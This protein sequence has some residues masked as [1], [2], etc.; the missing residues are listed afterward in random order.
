MVSF[1]LLRK[2][3]LQWN[4]FCFFTCFIIYF[5]SQISAQVWV[6]TPKQSRKVDSIFFDFGATLYDNDNYIYLAPSWNY[7]LNED[8]GF[9]FSLPANF[10]VLDREPT[11]DGQ[12]VGSLR[13]FDYNER[14]DYFR[15]VNYIWYGQYEREV[16]GK[17][18]FSFYAGDI[19]DGRIGNGT[20]LNQYYNNI[21]HDVYNV[22]ILSD[23]NSDYVGVQFFS[24]SL[25]S[26][27]V[28]AIR[29]YIKPLA[30]GR[31]LYHLYLIHKGMF[32][33]D[34]DEFEYVGMMQSRGNVADEA[35]RKK[36][37]EE[38]EEKKKKRKPRPSPQ[39]KYSKIE[40]EEKDEWYNR[41][42][43]G[44]TRA[45]DR[46]SPFLIGFS[47]N[48]FPLPR[49]N[50]DQPVV[51]EERRVTVEGFDVSYR[52]LNMKNIEFT[53]YLDVNRIRELENSGGTH[54]GFVVRIGDKD[55]NVVLRPELR[56]MSRNYIPMYFDT[57]YEVER[58][59]GIP[60]LNTPMNP[61]RNQIQALETTGGFNG[62]FHT[63]IFNFYNYAFEISYEDWE[64]PNNS[65]IFLASYIPLGSSFLLSF[66]YTKKGFEGTGDA[67]NVNNTAMG[68]AELS[69][70]LGPFQLRLQNIRKWTFV[71]TERNFK[72]FDEVRV[73]F[74]SQFIF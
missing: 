54:Y 28:N 65:R 23:F 51:N 5:S 17:T 40:I 20:I 44:Y 11:Q 56:R 67:L 37:L 42:T 46:N 74:S 12:N 60:D 30:I 4:L 52:F 45:F 32:Q 16:P 3:S 21:R 43:V 59:G 22:G 38:V 39:I 10:L 9:S 36:V 70:P 58:F 50:V 49:E 34:E 55:V 73:L 6:P 2:L 18:S 57:F 14:Q 53:T 68:A 48:G 72:A 66:Y 29:G 64:G 24:N 35:G 1:K 61:K 8:F 19:R 33:E 7:N 62:Y 26:R 71:E 63:L 27:N 15:V 41:L 25:Y 69:Y 13:R 47:P 31:S